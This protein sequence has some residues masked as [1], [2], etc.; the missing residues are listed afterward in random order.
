MFDRRACELSNRSPKKPVGTA[1]LLAALMLGGLSAPLTPAMAQSRGAAQAASG[2]VHGDMLH[3][4]MKQGDNLYV[5]AQRHMS[6]MTAVEKVRRLNHIANPRAVPVGTV[7]RIP[8]ALLKYRAE[9]ARL[10]AWR[11]DVGVGKTGAPTVGME[12]GE[13]IAIA[14]GQGGFVTLQLSNGSRVSIPSQSLV[15]IARLREYSINR[16]LDYEI[17]VD[18]G[19]LQTKAAP[20]KNP[21][22]RYRIRTPIAVSAVRGTEFRIKLEGD[23]VPSLT[24]VLEG[25]VEVGAAAKIARNSAPTPVTKGEGLAVTSDG[26]NIAEKL[27]PAPELVRPGKVQKDPTLQFEVAP[28]SG[29]TRYHAVF[30]TDASLSEQFAE[31]RSDTPVITYPSIPNGRYYVRVSALSPNGFEGFP[32]NYGFA[33]RLSS[34]SGTASPPAEDGSVLFKWD[35]MGEGKIINRFQLYRDSVETTPYIDEPGLAKSEIRLDRLPPGTWFW[36]VGISV[37]D[38]GAVTDSWTTAEKLIIAREE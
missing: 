28:V 12:L 26:K 27:L 37:F 1:W 10:V 7:I 2:M 29:A 23:A 13:G 8:V 25:T 18:K 4:R 11:G 35:A 32:A 14:T 34:V 3:Y 17:A 38:D 16:A 31:A 9:K 22:S 33:R 24:E 30:A 36:R 21:D 19:R 5:L 15:R 6:S 20:L